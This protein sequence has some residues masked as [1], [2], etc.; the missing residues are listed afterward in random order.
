MNEIIQAAKGAGGVGKHYARLKREWTTVVMALARS[1]KL[2]PVQRASVA[3]EWWETTARRDP[4]NITAGAKL[5]LDGLV[6]AGVL[7]D[8]GQDEIAGLEHRFI[9]R[10]QSA[11]VHV[12]ITEAP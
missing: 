9:R 5:V 3:F 10:A 1:A 7:P 6:A 2:R 8:D 11:G 4:D 12:T